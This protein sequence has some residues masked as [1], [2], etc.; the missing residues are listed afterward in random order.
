MI[1]VYIR[2]SDKEQNLEG[3]RQEIQAWLQKAGIAPDAVRWYE[4]KLTGKN[5]Q[6]PDFQKLRKAILK[7]TVETIICWKLDRLSRS[8][9]DGVRLIQ[10]WTEA[11]VRIVSVTQNIDL[12]GVVGQLIATVYF[13]LAEMELNHI[14]ERQAAGIKVAKSEGKYKG[15]KPG[16]TKGRPERA[17]QLRD[18][19]YQLAEIAAALKVTERTVQNYLRA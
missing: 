7:G 4:D 5:T 9:L 11:G 16:S 1:A 14:H 15:R 2:V 12:S 3:Q 13:A 6:R 8:L 17:R 18:K 10:E 19:G